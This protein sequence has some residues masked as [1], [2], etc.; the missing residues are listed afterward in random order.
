MTVEN[1]LKRFPDLNVLKYVVI[2][3]NATCPGWTTETILS[4]F[5]IECIKNKMVAPISYPA[6]VAFLQTNQV[7]YDYPATKPLP[8]L[9]A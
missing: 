3:L 7:I 9:T 1:F 6:S 2:L 8:S 5:Q 4:R